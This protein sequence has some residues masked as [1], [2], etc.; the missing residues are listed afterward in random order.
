MIQRTLKS[1]K[2]NKKLA[3]HTDQDFFKRLL[4]GV[5]KHL[6]SAGLC[7]LILPLATAKL[8]KQTARD[9]NLFVS[10]ITN[11]YSFKD[12]VA[13]RELLALSLTAA[14]LNTSEFVIYDAPKIYSRQY[15][16]VLKDF[17]TIF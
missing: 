11:I 6:T 12:S 16:H 13:H 17:L 5:S 15:Q 4:I 14:K 10:N 1:L 7:Y 8:V 9:N 3:K 2:A